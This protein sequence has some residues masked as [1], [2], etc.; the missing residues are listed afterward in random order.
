MK[1]KEDK[2][3]ERSDA[4]FRLHAYVN[5]RVQGVGFRFFV[6]DAAQELELTGW[7]RNLSDGRVEVLAEGPRDHLDR[8]LE[9]LHQGPPAS[10]VTK[11]DTIWESATAEFSD[12]R[13]VRTF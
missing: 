3:I 5:G 6:L 9:I 2:L 1:P 8:L 12:F 10:W 4:I 13:A 11:V 7:V